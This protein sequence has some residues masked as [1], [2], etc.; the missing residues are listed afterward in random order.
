MAEEIEKEGKKYYRCIECGLMYSDKK[1]A[2]KC[3]QWCAKNKSCNLEIIKYAV[4]D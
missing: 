4:K 2:Q 3:Q 1:T